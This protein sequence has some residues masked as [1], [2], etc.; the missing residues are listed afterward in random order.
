MF[1][2]FE[3]SNTQPYRKAFF[4]FP[5]YVIEDRFY[6]SLEKRESFECFRDFY[7]EMD[8]EGVWVKQVKA[9]IKSYPQLRQLLERL[10]RDRQVS[11]EEVEEAQ[12]AVTKASG[13]KP[14]HG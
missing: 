13:P 7:F 2:Q 11:E 9:I 4:F 12:G 5:E 14:D 10:A 6:T 8:N 3:F 1:Y